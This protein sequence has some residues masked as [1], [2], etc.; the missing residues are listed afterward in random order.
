[1]EVGELSIAEVLEVLEVSVMMMW[2]ACWSWVGNL[3]ARR[4]FGYK[5]Y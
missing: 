3:N 2:L 4:R 5:E 1:M